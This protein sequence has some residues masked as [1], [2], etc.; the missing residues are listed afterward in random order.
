MPASRL[1]AFGDR[2][3]SIVT[4]LLA[5]NLRAPHTAG[6]PAA[7]AVAMPQLVCVPCEPT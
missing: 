7:R 6:H 4:T 1:D 3:F 5:P 2:D